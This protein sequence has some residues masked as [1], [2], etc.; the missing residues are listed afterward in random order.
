MADVGTVVTKQTIV[1]DFVNA[2]MA[3][4]QN[5]GRWHSGNRPTFD[6]QRG[7][8]DSYNYVGPYS[9][10]QDVVVDPSIGMANP[11]TAALSTEL[12]TASVIV[13][14]LRNYAYGTTRVR[15]VFA[16][17]YYNT[18]WGEAGTYGLQYGYAH[19][20]DNYLRSQPYNVA[21]PVVNDTIIASQLINF[22]NSLRSAA[23]TDTYGDALDLRICHTSCHS[24]CHASRGRR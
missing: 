2:V 7:A 14:V 5:R 13:D 4:E 11:P 24:S 19:L 10:I 3:P 1:D 18:S 15:Y 21:G 9:V 16:G 22:Y 12:I 6:Y 23:N 20:N 8:W 17:I